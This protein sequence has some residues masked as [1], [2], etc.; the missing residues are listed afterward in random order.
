[1]VVDPIPAG[2]PR[3]SPYLCCRG[4][5]AAIEFYTDVFGATERM[6]MPG[7]SPED[8]GHAELEIGSSIVMLAD[9]FPDHGFLSP[10]SLGGS[11]V[12]VHVYVEDVDAVFA[13]ALA[14]G[15]TESRPVDDQFYGDR[16]GQFTDPWGHRW[17]VASH[18]EDVS[19][20]EMARRAAEYDGT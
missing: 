13:R 14:L 9:E 15:A 17:S 12:T 16:L 11:P 1:M 4:A 7:D 10:Q 8:I 20:E 19:E 18:V 6:R 2:Y 3:V 5:A